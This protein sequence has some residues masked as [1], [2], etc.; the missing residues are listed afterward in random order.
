MTGQQITIAADDGGEF[1]AYLA[2]PPGTSASGAAPAPGII[3]LHE[4]FGVTGW[5]HETADMFAEHG[6]VVIAPD[7]F[8][9]MERN[10]AGD[11][12]DPAMTDK[13][14]D[15]K[16]R[17]DHDKAVDDMAAVMARLKSMGEC[18]GKIGV[19]GF[20]TGGTMAYLAAARLA[21]D[22]AAPYY[23]T[24]IHEFLDDARTITCPTIFH[25]GDADDRVPADMPDQLRAAV[26]GM[27]HVAVHE[28]P[29][30]HAF[31]H[32]QR[33]DYY[34]KDAAL[35]AH[36]RTFELFDALR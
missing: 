36:A 34:E 17:I 12:N 6:Y 26:A 11:F 31:A 19:T 32:S 24:Q 16:A 1:D 27:E 13:G 5:I 9:R 8:W 22:A 3:M 14:R 4:I 33:A 29:A 20:C 35:S 30:G 21:P 7:M 18:N 23:G 2:L 15:F 10:F 28:Y 25:V